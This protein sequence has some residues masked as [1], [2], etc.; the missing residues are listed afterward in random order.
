MFMMEDL[1][2][3]WAQPLA[4]EHL[5]VVGVGGFLGNQPKYVNSFRG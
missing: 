4:K 2:L 5:M 3:N 1:G